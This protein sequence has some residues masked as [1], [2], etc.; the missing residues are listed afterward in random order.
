M[1][2]HSKS[3]GLRRIPNPND[4]NDFAGLSTANRRHPL[5]V[6]FKINRPSVSH[7]PPN[8]CVNARVL[9]LRLTPCQLEVGLSGLSLTK[10][11]SKR[12][13]SDYPLPS[14][15]YTLQYS[16]YCYKALSSAA[17]TTECNWTALSCPMGHPFKIGARNT[18]VNSY[19]FTGHGGH[20]F[21]KTR[22]FQHLYQKNC[23]RW[24]K[25]PKIIQIMTH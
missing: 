8:I 16:N 20:H 12:A 6:S 15:L 14:L 19:S 24:P 4:V 1:R 5:H 10:T 17:S 3:E 18:R 11:L 7:F 21:P 13:L 25:G 22:Q 23:G 9:T 2:A